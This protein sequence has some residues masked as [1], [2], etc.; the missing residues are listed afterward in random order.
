MAAVLA[1]LADDETHV[2]QRLDTRV[3]APTLETF[4]MAFD[5]RL[6]TSHQIG[7]CRRWFSGG[8]N[9]RRF[10]THA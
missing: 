1:Q 9:A 8:T 10:G 4:R 2:V 5:E 3:R 6:G 7:R